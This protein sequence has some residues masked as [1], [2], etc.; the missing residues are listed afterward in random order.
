M[1]R[2]VKDKQ[3]RMRSLF[4][5]VAATVGVILLLSMHYWSP[6]EIRRRLTLRRWEGVVYSSDD[7]KGFRARQ[8][9][10]LDSIESFSILTGPKLVTG[11]LFLNDSKAS[12]INI[13]F[14][15]WNPKRV[16]GFLLDIPGHTYQHSFT[17]FEVDDFVYR[18]QKGK[19]IAFEAVVQID[20]N[21]TIQTHL[22]KS[23]NMYLLDQ[24]GNRLSPTVAL[25][26]VDSRTGMSETHDE[27]RSF[28]HGTVEP[29]AEKTSGQS[30]AP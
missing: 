27:T 15:A 5:L 12:G 4:G 22:S 21:T 19:E 14:L 26:I 7:L 10:L 2:L 1:F 16:K 28:V 3:Y 30:D 9:E 13:T 8:V 18:A 20:D 17:E 23:C 24:D 29:P 25:Q 6:P 11:T